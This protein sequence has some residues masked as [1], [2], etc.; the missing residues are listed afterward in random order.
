MGYG[1]LGSQDYTR[2]VEHA[3]AGIGQILTAL[4]R[5][6]LTSNTLVIFTND[7]GGE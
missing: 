3:D 1:A 2:M 6:G 4:L 5:H 7:N